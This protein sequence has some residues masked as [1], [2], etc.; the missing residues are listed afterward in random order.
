[1]LHVLGRFAAIC[2]Y[3][4][5]L[6]EIAGCAEGCCAKRGLCAFPLEAYS[7]LLSAFRVQGRG[8]TPRHRGP[9]GVGSEAVVA[10]L[11][12]LIASRRPFLL[13][14]DTCR[15]PPLNSGQ[16]PSATGHRP[17][18]RNRA[19]RKP[20]TSHLSPPYDRA[21]RDHAARNPLPE[22]REPGI[23]IISASYGGAVSRKWRNWQTRKIQVLVPARAWGFDSPLSHHFG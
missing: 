19:A 17:L 1:M 11:F 8:D 12:F 9:E 23:V 4:G 6:Q 7:F 3:K 18:P 5:V 13:K 10:A 22:S 2:S 21:A 20:I 14:A 16:A 15:T